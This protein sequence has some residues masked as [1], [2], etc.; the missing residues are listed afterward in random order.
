MTGQGNYDVDIV[1]CIDST[2]S[3]G[4][5]IEEVKTN[6]LALHGMIDEAM[7][8]EG[9]DIANLRVKVI[10]FGDYQTDAQPM[11]ESPFYTL[12]DQSDELSTFVQGISA[13]GGGDIPENGFEA[14]ATAMKSDWIAKQDGRKRRQVIA[15]FTD[16]PALALGERAGCPGYPTDL[17]KTMAELSA[18]WEGTDQMMGGTYDPIA[19]RLIAYVPNDES[20]T[21]LEPWN[22]FTPKY[23]GGKGCEGIDMAEIT[24][25]IVGSFGG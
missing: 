4:H 1:L 11:R 17:P 3:M 18:W 22:R 21:Q 19:G 2:G 7:T 10:A 14:I 13:T 24:D 25:T 16:A 20:W 12:P 23:T 15:I 8:M 5:I 9:K 6:A